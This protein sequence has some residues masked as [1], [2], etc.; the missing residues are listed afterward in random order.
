MVVQ[1]PLAR[2]K[3]I[4]TGDGYADGIAPVWQTGLIKHGAS[5]LGPEHRFTV[6]QGL[7]LLSCSFS[8][9]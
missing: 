5:L 3:S 4:F 9:E 2:A 7:A 6:S 1:G 8:F